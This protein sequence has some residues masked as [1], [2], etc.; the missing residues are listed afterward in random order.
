L[1]S[2]WNSTFTFGYV[3]LN[4]AAY[5]FILPFCTRS[6][7]WVRTV[8]VPE[9]FAGSSGA[10]ASAPFEVP[11]VEVQPEARRAAPTATAR[12]VRRFMC[13]DSV[14]W[15]GRARAGWLI[16]HSDSAFSTGKVPFPPR[17]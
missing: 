12:A 11:A 1:V 6:V 2:A 9:T 5:C 16:R 4:A 8:M 10:S 7:R 14:R 13:I 15:D 17:M 3:R